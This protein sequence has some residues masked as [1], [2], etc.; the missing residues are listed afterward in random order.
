[1]KTKKYFHIALP[2]LC[3]WFSIAA[4]GC[5][6]REVVET[7]M[8]V[9]TSDADNSK[10]NV[11]DRDGSTLTSGDQGT[12]LEDREI[13]QAI[14]RALVADN[15]LSTVSKN[16]KIITTAGQVTLRGPVKTVEEKAAIG[17]LAQTHAKTGP[18][19]NQLEIKSSQ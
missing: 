1:M 6:E 11:R 7:P 8:A 9:K 16:V 5:S 15:T 18:V 19:D 12:S 17:T 14:R 3:A 10:K 2:G 4:I 13:T